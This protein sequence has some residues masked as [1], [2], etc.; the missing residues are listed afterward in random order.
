M[1]SLIL[2]AYNEARRLPAS[3]ARC[4]EFLQASGIRGEIIVAD[5]GSTDRT[6]L[7]F[8]EAAADLSTTDVE[9]RYLPLAHRGKGA[10]VRAGVMHATGDPIAFLDA[11]LTIPVDVLAPFVSAIAAGADIAIASRY[12]PG[13]TVRRPGVR[14]VMGTGYRAIACVIAPAGVNDTQCGGKAYTAE[15]ARDLFSRQRLD[16]FAFDT[17]V[18]YLAR[19]AGYRVTE[20]PFALA[21]DS[22]SSVDLLSD[23]PRML[24]DL[25]RIR[26]N[27][28]R[29][30]YR[31]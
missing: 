31:P 3:L 23:A 20:I 16:G 26:A 5:D 30:R 8:G 24:A 1:L 18:L 11:D 15:A 7:A 10:A 13:S 25:F 19:R 22:E 9:L 27:D 4:A 2:P 12:I 6:A 17:E 21:A 28:L 14:R 29:G